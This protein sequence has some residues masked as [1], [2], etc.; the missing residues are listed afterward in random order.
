M[1]VTTEKRSQ[2]VEKSAYPRISSDLT[3]V[4][5]GPSHPTMHGALRVMLGLDGETIVEAIPEIGYLHRCFEK[6]SEHRTYHQ[7]IPFSDRLNYASPGM[8]NVGYAMAVEKLLGIE[9]PK[10][11][12]YIRVLLCELSRISDHCLCL[13]PQLVDLGAL[14]V[15]WYLFQV[16][17][18]M[19]DLIEPLCGAR[20][21]TSYTRIGGV[22]E[23]IPDGWIDRAREMIKTS[24]PLLEDVQGLL[25]KNR[26]FID[27]TRWIGAISPEDAISYGFTGPC[28]RA[29]GVPY[30]VRK[31]Y[32]YYDYDRFEFD[33]PLGDNGDTFDRYMVRMKEMYQSIRIVEQVLENLP[34]G[35]IMI[36]DPKLTLPPKEN[37]YNEIEGLIHHFKIIIDG[38]RPPAGEVY[39]YTEAANG[40]L[41][42]YIVSDGSGQPYRIKVRPPCYAVY[43]AYGELIKG[44]LI[45]DAVAILSSMNIVAGELDR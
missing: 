36:D 20:M 8:N 2:D 1:E 3:P 38:I 17:E 14:T 15:Y 31:A 40:E 44:H 32:P 11:A 27:R 34:D 24:K 22:A 4:N 6:M 39:S 19:Y 12:Q 33:I 29:A 7:V 30:D 41:G 5:F 18:K 26:I 37:V 35:P 13:G 42:F 10:R 9:I 25:N 23:D 21:M 28:L 43:Q 45:A 16:R